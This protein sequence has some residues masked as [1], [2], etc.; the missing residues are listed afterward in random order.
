MG[1]ALAQAPASVTLDVYTHP[2]AGAD[3]EMARQLEQALD[4]RAF[5]RDAAAEG[6]GA[7]RRL[8]SRLPSLAKETSMRI[9]T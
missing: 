5:V 1:A 7:E 6:Q 4:E 9:R 3:G 2:L 8:G